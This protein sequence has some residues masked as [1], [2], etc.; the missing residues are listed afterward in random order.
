MK[1]CSDVPRFSSDR[2]SILAAEP[3]EDW[4]VLLNSQELDS[5]QHR[6]N[7]TNCPHGEKIEGA[8]IVPW[9]FYKRNLKR[10]KSNWSCYSKKQGLKRFLAEEKK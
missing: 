5:E 3:E 9:F 8:S 1:G 7:E 6:V 4:A 10:P 2:R